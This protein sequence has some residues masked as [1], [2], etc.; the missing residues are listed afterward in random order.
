MLIIMIHA[1]YYDTHAYYYD[2][3]K[4]PQSFHS[5]HRLDLSGFIFSQIKFMV[6]YA[7]FSCFADA[8]SITGEEWTG[9]LLRT[10]HLLGKSKYLS[11]RK[12]SLFFL[13]IIAFHDSLVVQNFIMLSKTYENFCIHNLVELNTNVHIVNI[14]EIP[15][16]LQ[17]S[18]SLLILFFCES[19]WMFSNLKLKNSL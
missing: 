5:L 17:L 3:R 10:S 6:H 19:L 1:Y 4:L 15:S 7:K 13:S 8:N 11:N 14:R 2:T 9:A 18:T 12:V 16:Y